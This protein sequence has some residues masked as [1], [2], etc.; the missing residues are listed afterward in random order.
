M[1][2][3]AVAAV[4]SG[5][6]QAETAF[7]CCDTSFEIA[8]TGPRAGAAVR[9]ARQC[10][11]DL[12]CRLDAFDDGSAVARL[13]ATG[14]VDDPHVA[15]L[16]RR[17]LAYAEQT[18]GAFDI[19]LG[20][21]EHTLK[22]F[23]RGEVDTAPGGRAG[24][25]GRP[26]VAT[27]PATVAVDGNRVETDA[28]LDLNGLAKGYVVDRTAAALLGAGRSGHVDGG[29]DIA[30]PRGPVAVESPYGDGSPLSV[31]DTDW[32]V[33]TS[34]G[35]R[36]RR[37]GVDHV[38]RPQDGGL[39]GRH[40]LVTVVASRDCTEADAL[41]TALAASPLEDALRLV[42]GSP[43]VEALVVHDGVFH[44][45]SGFAAHEASGRGGGRVA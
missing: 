33:A 13:N 2:E 1:L 25:I 22:A 7:R 6:G 28:P 32:N 11:R 14:T 42:E 24:A 12:E 30:S 43:R 3:V 45:S 44:R 9:R 40:D 34:A 17:G 18:D 16:V 10:A 21:T 19:R 38:Y 41:A 20:R 29:G 5:I 31:L 15:A 37:A 8:A 27:D 39:G 36:R 26:S 35:Y 4:R 23:L